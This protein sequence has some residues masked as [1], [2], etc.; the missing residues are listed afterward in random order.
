[1]TSARTASRHSLIDG[2]SDGGQDRACGGDG[3]RGTKDSQ[4][5][6]GDGGIGRGNV[7]RRANRTEIKRARGGRSGITAGAKE[8]SN[9]RSKGVA[10]S[11]Q[12]IML[13]KL[14]VLDKLLSDELLHQLP[15]DEDREKTRKPTIA[16]TQPEEDDSTV[17]SERNGTGNKT[18]VTGGHLD[19]FRAKEAPSCN[20]LAEKTACGSEDSQTLVR[21]PK[22][23]MTVADIHS[24]DGGERGD[25]AEATVKK[26]RK[27]P[28]NVERRHKEALPNHR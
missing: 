7:D 21:K 22:I 2:G 24:P 15:A 10:T 26:S 8:D 23:A 25:A 27:E 19:I 12:E 9:I 28:M 13:E 5:S 4:S 1:M 17:V 18:T 3:E 20:T 11:R 6:G 14:K 16:S